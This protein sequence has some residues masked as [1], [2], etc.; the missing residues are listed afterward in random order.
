MSHC[1]SGGWTL[2]TPVTSSLREIH[3]MVRTLRGMGLLACLGGCQTPSTGIDS[4]LPLI[5][6]AVI[7]PITDAESFEWRDGDYYF[8]DKNDAKPQAGMVSAKR[9]G[10][11]AT[12]WVGEH[13]GSLH[14]DVEL[15]VAEEEKSASPDDQ[16]IGLVLYYRGVPTDQELVVTVRGEEVVEAIC[17]NV[18]SFSPVPQSAKELIS[19]ERA[20]D[21]WRDHLLGI[22]QEWAKQRLELIKDAQP[23]LEYVWSSRRSDVGTRDILAPTWVLAGPMMVDAQ[24]GYLFWND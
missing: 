1:S 12:R 6:I 24:E 4:M 5:Q 2:G 13:F 15:R 20:K 14:K 17:N 10:L 7:K 3:G 8:Y 19:P 16:D 9:A 21:A 11:I 22:S 18:V 23:R